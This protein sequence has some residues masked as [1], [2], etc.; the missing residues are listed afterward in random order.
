MPVGLVGL[1]G[2]EG[3]EL[4]AKLGV[5]LVPPRLTVPLSWLSLLEETLFVSLSLV[6][7]DMELERGL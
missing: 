2:L 3:F 6:A 1:V 4:V 5:S 7:E